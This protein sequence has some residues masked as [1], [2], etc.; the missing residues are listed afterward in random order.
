MLLFEGSSDS[1]VHSFTTRRYGAWA[2]HSA[3]PPA[4]FLHR[5]LSCCVVFRSLWFVLLPSRP[6]SRS[7]VS[8]VPRSSVRAPIVASPLL[9]FAHSF[10]ASPIFTCSAQFGQF[11]ITVW[12]RALLP[13][14]FLSAACSACRFDRA[15]LLRATRRPRS[16][17]SPSWL[18]LAP[19]D[20]LGTLSA[21]PG[22]LQPFPGFN[23]HYVG[24]VT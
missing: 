1:F 16:F 5:A 21:L 6:L 19:S 9:V 3:C 24:F 13:T 11:P 23:V 2:P 20:L 8:S 18:S 15:C 7:A 4:K 14:A 12:S 17:L 10:L 22:F